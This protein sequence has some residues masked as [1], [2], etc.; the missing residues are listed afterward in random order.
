MRNLD[1]SARGRARVYVLTVLGT[2]VCIAVAFVVDSFS[3]ETWTWRWGRD[4]H[5]NII[6]P[7]LLA[8]FFFYL[9]LNKMRQLS[10]AHHELAHLAATDSLTSLLNRRAFT[11]VVE[12]YIQRMASSANR[13]TDAL[14]VIDVDHFK[15]INDHFGHDIG[16]EAL[17][18]IAD[19]ICAGLQPPDLAG[20][21]GGEEF[22][23]FL[24]AK[25]AE[26]AAAIAERMRQSVR[27]VAFAPGGSP[28]RLTI[29][30][31]GVIF[32][33][34]PTFRDLYRKA[35]EQLYAAKHSGRDCVKLDF[36]RPASKSA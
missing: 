25:T 10:I 5:N 15:T 33:D 14:L 7:L 29:S 28:R 26:G 17:K 12:G 35:D 31:G 36:A 20:R 2:A 34:C 18:Q 32:D 8:P 24:P 9:L 3:F 22:G 1:W 13:S 30:I 27:E 21:L 19:A 23:V 16:D 6:I 11:E 4:P